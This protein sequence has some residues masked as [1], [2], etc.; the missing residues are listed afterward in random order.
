[1]LI[2]LSYNFGCEVVMYTGSAN[3]AVMFQIQFF[4]FDCRLVLYTSF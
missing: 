2:L 4:L 1:V 3:F